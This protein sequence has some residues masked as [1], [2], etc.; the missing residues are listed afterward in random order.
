MMEPNKRR[1]GPASPVV[2]L[3]VDAASPVPMY[4]Q[5]YEGLRDAILSGRLARGARLPSSRALAA[6]LGVARNTVLQAFDQLRSEGYLQ[7]RRGGG[8]RAREVIP[9][10]LITVRRPTKRD[11]TKSPQLTSGGVSGGS[12][13]SRVAQPASPASPASPRLSRRGRTLVTSGSMLIREA[14][15]YPDDRHGLQT[16]RISQQLAKM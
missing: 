16:G 15:S 10:S 7:G 11:A 14:L 1:R 6:D 5:V 4:R 3:V 12:R 8:T 9:D 13:A 2:H